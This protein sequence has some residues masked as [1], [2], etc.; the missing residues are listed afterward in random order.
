M[1]EPIRPNFHA[2]LVHF[3]I[4]LL[5]IGTLI[6]ALSFLG[7][8]R[9]S[10]RVAARWM[11]LFGALGSFAATFSGLYALREMAG[12]SA[13]SD[14][15]LTWSELRASNL[16]SN[17]VTS[18]LMFD[19][20]W[21]GIG[22]SAGAMLIVMIWIG[23]CDRSRKVFHVPFVLLLL[24]VVGV[25]IMAAREGGEAV[26]EHGV[27]VSR[28]I[29]VAD[30]S[31]KPAYALV[32]IVP[33]IQ[34]HVT[35]AGLAIGLTLVSIATSWRATVELRRPTLPPLRQEQE[36]ALIAAELDPDPIVI[37]RAPAGRAW[38]MSFL[39]LLLTASAG[40]WFLAHDSGSWAWSNLKTQIADVPSTES[41][42]RRYVH[43]IAGA[44][45]LVVPLAFAFFSRV[46][47]RSRL[48]IFLMLPATIAL[49]IVQVWVGC[50]LLLDTPD[51]PTFKFQPTVVETEQA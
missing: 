19:H 16:L 31:T 8:R 21:L 13:G 43:A 22:A 14:G 9:S 3:P 47:R 48:M 46:A 17:N 5:V 15:V 36:A 45:L 23:A 32:D 38:L 26:Y 2:V 20:L 29:D 42:E 25:T 28:T 7:W 18:D 40:V 44:A 39:L 51:G 41:P 4:A 49:L 34:L 10:V 50:L 30:A 33:P 6:E 27:G 37:G 12:V 11:I 35:L 24:C 1:F